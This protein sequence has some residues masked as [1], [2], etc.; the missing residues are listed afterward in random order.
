[1][2]LCWHIKVEYARLNK[3]Q[4]QEL[5]QWKYSKYGKAAKEKAFK[6]YKK[7]K[8]K[9]LLAQI[10]SIHQQLGSTNE[11]NVKGDELGDSTQLSDI[12]ACISS[13]FS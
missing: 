5:Y 6:K 11:R 10:N 1:M 3:S 7:P 9:Q 4:I 13:A 2:D 12:K 8:K